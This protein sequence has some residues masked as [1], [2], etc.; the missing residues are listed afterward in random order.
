M[1]S[2]KE[3]SKSYTAIVDRRFTRPVDDGVCQIGA[4]RSYQV[5]TPSTPMMPPCRP[6]AAAMPQAS[7]IRW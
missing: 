1:S 5:T 2:R 6:S 7:S 4:S 3:N